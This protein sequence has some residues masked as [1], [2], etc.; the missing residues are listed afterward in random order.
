MA[1]RKLMIMTACLSLVL[2]Q[3]PITNGWWG[4]RRRRGGPTV[5]YRP[6]PTNPCT[7]D[8]LSGLVNSHV[9]P[10][11]TNGETV[12]HGESVHFA[13]NRD[14]PVLYRLTSGHVTRVC[15]NGGWTGSALVCSNVDEC[16]EG[17]NRC[18]DNAHCHD[19]DGSYTCSCPS[20]WILQADKHTCVAPGC[21]PMDGIEHGRV[22]GSSTQTAQHELRVFFQCDYGYDL[23]GSDVSQCNVGEW[24]YPAGR[25]YCL[26][27]DECSRSTP[28]HDC[29]Q[30]C[31]NT[32]G[33]YR[34]E[35]TEGFDLDSD[36]KSCN[37]V[38]SGENRCRHGEC[39]APNKCNCDHGWTSQACEQAI[40][41]PPCEH[42][43][44]VYPQVCVC[45]QGWKGLSCSEPVCW[46][47]C[48]HGGT[49][50]GP[51]KCACPDGF[52]GNRCEISFCEDLPPPANGLVNCLQFNKQ[53]VCVV[54]CKAGYGFS[55]PIENP[56]V[57]GINRYWSN[58]LSKQAIPDCSI[59]TAFDVIDIVETSY[60]FEGECA[61]LSDDGRHAISQ[62]SR[63]S[64]LDIFCPE[65]CT[66]VSIS[67]TVIHCGEIDEVD[68]TALPKEKRQA[69]T[70]SILTIEFEI[71]AVGLGN[72]TL[73]KYCTGKC[74]TAV[75]AAARRVH[76][77]GQAIKAQ[78]VKEPIEMMIEGKTL[79]MLA[80]SVTVSKPKS[81]CPGKGE[82]KIGT[83]C[84]TCPK[85]A[86]LTGNKCSLCP[87]GFY[88][89]EI[90]QDKCK[91]CPKGTTTFAAG[92][93][94]IQNCTVNC[95]SGSSSHTGL[96]PCT[97]CPLDTFQEE[98]GQTSCKRCPNATIT[99]SLGTTSKSL[100]LSKCQRET[101]SLGFLCDD[102]RC[103]SD[104]KVCDLHEDC[105]DNSDETNC[106]D[107][108]VCTYLQSCTSDVI[109]ES[110]LCVSD[111]TLSARIDSMVVSHSGRRMVL[112]I[113]NVSVYQDR[114]SATA[115]STTDVRLYLGTRAIT[116]NCPVLEIGKQYLLSG[117]VNRGNKM[118]IS[119]RSIS[120][121]WNEKVKLELE[122]ALDGL[123]D[124][125]CRKI[126]DGPNAQ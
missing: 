87:I 101:C 119:H 39:V 90:S 1:F 78:L 110:V 71:K 18:H 113:S 62:K 95:N 115:N 31:V 81:R 41:S 50:T 75:I 36:K 72:E 105:D 91:Q 126:F 61:D 117:H 94:S 21:G 26:D 82:V 35:C 43:Q 49:C 104:L 32:E 77:M 125:Q 40:C 60:E 34:C 4:R 89:D 103:L 28:P 20:G 33:G 29:N 23:N 98:E 6:A 45:N 123:D 66:E 70:K 19:N 24:H 5:V 88:Q 11:Y 54:F 108:A 42:G 73:S 109:H 52:E 12:T 15:F 85:G 63:K 124:R 7:G 8:L 107:D 37:P 55:A 79:R 112:R 80:S 38:C 69:D 93:R 27:I 111:F 122:K 51:K 30:A 53:R 100:C 10:P 9:I 48:K 84:M 59:A 76:S 83:R 99:T 56:Y 106:M 17:T 102:C 47:G 58:E 120:A 57:C 22:I 96:E 86:F 92:S 3:S 116:C 44:C 2:L 118:V 67:A 121:Q 14:G 13:C 68:V 74:R 65:G 64:V 25:P 97:K 16:E 114:K 46:D